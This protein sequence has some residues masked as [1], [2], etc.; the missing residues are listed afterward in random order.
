MY[1]MRG[2]L[3]WRRWFLGPTP[4]SMRRWGVDTVPHASTTSLDA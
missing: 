4:L 2:M 3:N 1:R